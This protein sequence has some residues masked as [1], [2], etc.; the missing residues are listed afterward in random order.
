MLAR[1]LQVVRCPGPARKND[2]TE[3]LTQKTVWYP[4]LGVGRELIKTVKKENCHM[5]TEFVV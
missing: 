4:A 2:D 3:M 1:G 5:R